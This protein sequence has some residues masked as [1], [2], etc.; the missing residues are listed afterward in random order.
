MGNN[1]FVKLPYKLPRHDLCTF[2]DGTF[3]QYG[4]AQKIADA[5]DFPAPQ[6]NQSLCTLWKRVREVQWKEVT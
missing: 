5:S 3:T 1:Q 2:C 6:N 4:I